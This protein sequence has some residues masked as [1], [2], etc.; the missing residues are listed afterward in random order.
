MSNSVRKA[1][2]EKHR[3]WEK[4]LRNKN[5]E[6]RKKEFNRIRNK[7]RKLT[8]NLQKDYEMGIEK[9][10]KINPKRFW[11]YVKSKTS[12]KHGIS[13]L[14]YMDNEGI[15]R[16]TVSDEEKAVVLS[17]FFK[18]VFTNEV[19]DPPPI[20]EK[21]YH[22]ELHNLD[23]TEE[24]IGA[25]LYQLNISKSPGPDSFHSRVLK[26]LYLQLLRPI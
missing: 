2:K 15:E 26:E 23:I 8:R 9:D 21:D 5:D 1:I 6:N 24:M 7:V 22:S 3:A 4:C 17:D 25:K 11:Q 20:E 13:D 10:S 19:G 12:I 16:I 14:V 18:S